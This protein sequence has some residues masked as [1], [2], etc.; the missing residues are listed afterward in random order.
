MATKNEHS[1]ELSAEDRIEL[2][3]LSNHTHFLTGDISEENIKKTIQWIVYEN[4]DDKKE[5]KEKVLTL[6]INSTGGEL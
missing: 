4:L 1:S 3:F 5:N 2:R 6:Y